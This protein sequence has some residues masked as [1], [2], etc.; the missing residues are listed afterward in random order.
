MPTSPEAL[1][2]MEKATVSSEAFEVGES[3]LCAKAGR[4]VGGN[5]CGT[6]P[7]APSS[8]PIITHPSSKEKNP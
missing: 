1:P 2:S 5:R 8:A 3:L 7:T 4:G 6:Q